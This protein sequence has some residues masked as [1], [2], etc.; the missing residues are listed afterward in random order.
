[1]KKVV[2]LSQDEP[3]FLT[4]SVELLVDSLRQKGF[5]VMVGVM[6]ASP[7]GRKF[8][9]AQKAWHTLRIFGVYFFIFYSFKIF[10]A[11]IFQRSLVMRLNSRNVHYMKITDVNSPNTIQEL[12][13]WGAEIIIS[14]A[15]NQILKKE[16]LNTWPRKILNVHTAKL[17]KYRGLMPAFW[18]MKHN[19]CDTAV[20]VFLVDEGIDSGPI[21]VQNNHKIVEQSHYELIKNTKALAV[22]SAVEAIEKLA[23][24]KFHLLDND[25]EAST[26]FGFPT[27]DDVIEFKKRGGKLI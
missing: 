1:M 17:P 7:F 19:E 16:F 9:V 13:D 6:G 8:N 12:R 15:G 22:V 27:R 25:D 3:L 11:K 5:E 20:S 2:V 23:V 14:F 10:L 26:Y 24:G 18:V 21:L 4:E